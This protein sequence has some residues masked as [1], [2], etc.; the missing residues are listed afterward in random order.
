ME[1]IIKYKDGREETFE[2]VARVFVNNQN[3][4]CMR[5]WWVGE[6][7]AMAYIPMDLIESYSVFA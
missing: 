5:V 2:D 7:T 4:L 3:E 6:Q 1:V